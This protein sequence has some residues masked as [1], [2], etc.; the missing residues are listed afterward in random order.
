MFEQPWLRRLSPAERVRYTIALLTIAGAVGGGLTAAR[1]AQI[2][3]DRAE[4]ARLDDAGGG[5][6]AGTAPVLPPGQGWI[7]PTDD[8]QCD[9]GLGCGY[10]YCDL[11]DAG[12]PTICTA[13]SSCVSG[14]S[15]KTC[16]TRDSYNV[17]L[18]P[19]WLYL[20]SLCM[21]LDDC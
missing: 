2:A 14:P 15:G 21:V 18:A 12:G 9:S 11:G 1:R 13:G 8:Y 16:V 3:A 4:L 20:V 19:V 7:S 5:V 10:V 6:R 17:L